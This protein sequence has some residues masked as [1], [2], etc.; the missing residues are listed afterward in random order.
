MA[1]RALSY[2]QGELS[3]RLDELEGVHQTATGAGPGRRWGTAQF[4]GQLFVA[5]VG[6]FQS[7][8]RSLHDEALD[9][10][11]RGSPTSAQ[12]ATLAAQTRKLDTGNPRPSALGSDF[13]RLGMK[14]VPSIQSRAHGATRLDRLE[15][16]VELRNGIAHADD[17]R[18]ARLAHLA[19]N[20]RAVRTLA[21]YR[22]HRRALNGLVVDMDDVVADHV[23]GLT[24]QGRP[25]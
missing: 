23:G 5:L 10:L 6:Q 16:A 8:A 1:S 25:W 11:R 24:G 3:D 12:L 18:I 9:V 2:W 14:L 17:A 13:G 15:Q 22:R 19:P 21:S 4:N 20:R 7:F